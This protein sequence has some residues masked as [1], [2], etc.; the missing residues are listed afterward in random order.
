M[1]VVLRPC[2]VP[3]SVSPSMSCLTLAY[4]ETD[5]LP[6]CSI[7]FGANSLKKGGGLETRRIELRFLSASDVRATRLLGTD[8]LESFGFEVVGLYD[9]PTKDWSA[10]TQETWRD[11]G[12]CPSPHFYIAADSDWLRCGRIRHGDALKHF[13]LDGAEAFIEVAA[14]S[15]SWREWQWSD[16][17]RD[18]N[19]DPA[20]VVGSG[21]GVE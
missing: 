12:V 16:G 4:V 2:K 17:L 15:F 6:E 20:H 18:D 21:H 9:G 19:Q 13:V 10:R 3:W 8:N 7:V 1:T 5:T 11:T 14:E